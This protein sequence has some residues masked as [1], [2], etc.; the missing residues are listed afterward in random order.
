MLTESFITAIL[1]PSKPKANAVAKDIG[2]HFHDFQPAPTLKTGFKKSSTLPKCLAVSTSHIFAAQTEKAVVHVYS[3]ERGNQEA[4]VPFPERI[5]SVALAGDSNGAG[6]LVLGTE[7]GRVILWE[8]CTGRQTST[9][10]SHLQSIT[11][12]AVDPSSNFLLSGSSDSNIHVWSLPAL[13]SFSQPSATDSTQPTPRSPLRTLSN[14]R[15][16]IT[17]LITGHGSSVANIAIS[18]SQDNTCIVWDY[19]TGTLLRTFLLPSTPLCLALDPAD[20]ACYAGYED[21][22]V[23]LIDFYKTPT[24]TN[25][26]YDSAHQS[27]PSQ[28]SPKDQWPPPN[29]TLGAALCIAVNYEGNTLI[30]G[31]QSGKIISWDVAKGRYSSELFDLSAPVTNLHMLPPT[32]FPYPTEP[33]LKVHNIVKPRYEAS[34]SGSEGDSGVVPA[35]YNFTAQFTS[36]L[37]L[38]RLSA[39]QTLI[40][41]PSEFDTALSHPSFPTAMLDEGLAELAS[42]NPA[43][44]TNKKASIPSFDGTNDIDPD[45]VQ[46]ANDE[47]TNLK[48]EI[49]DLTDLVQSQHRTQKWTWEKLLELNTYRFERE[50]SDLVVQQ[51]RKR[52]RLGSGVTGG[53]VV[54]VGGG[55]AENGVGDEMEDED[56]GDGDGDDGGGEESDSDE[57]ESREDEMTDTD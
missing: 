24:L 26:L 2:I 48:K 40:P 34:L 15:A 6:V 3:R 28:A 46:P 31:H 4:T 41:P 18:G 57:E 44:T 56:D 29:D 10:Q 32:G 16:A 38:P 1:P 52:R 12:L 49:A 17:H 54:E 51:R 13:L 14:H 53:S 7:E 5:H 42:W 45:E 22:T 35:N 36:S 30:T 11:T 8:L 21:G 20:R 19:H 25:T 39:D 9:P 33:K 47:L 27:T 43:S 37:A 23:Q 55:G 50:K